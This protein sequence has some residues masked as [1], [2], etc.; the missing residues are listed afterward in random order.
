ICPSW[1][2]DGYNNSNT[3]VD[4]GT[5]GGAPT[6]TPY[7][8]GAPEYATVAAAGPNGTGGN[9]T[10]AFTGKVAPT[11]YK[12][13]VGTHIAKSGTPNHAPKEN[14]GT[15]LTGRSGLTH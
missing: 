13:M 12:V 7:T 14:G 8:Y 6:A 11:N 15:V 3:T 1:A 10:A 2:G 9:T 5:A 4:I